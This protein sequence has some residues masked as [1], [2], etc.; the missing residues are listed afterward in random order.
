[1]TE[2]E[3]LACTDPETVL[4]YLRDKV[5]DRKLRLFAVACAR[6]FV[7]LSQAER[8]HQAV[9]LS[10]QF[11]DGLVTN[12]KRGN[13]YR[14]AKAVALGASI[15]FQNARHAAAY[16]A[17]ANPYQAFR[18][19]C[20]NGQMAAGLSS[21]RGYNADLCQQEKGP[22]CLLLRDIFGNPFR[23]PPSIAPSMLT[24]NDAVVVRLAQ[25]IYEDRQLPAGTLDNSRLAVLADALEEAGCADADMLGHLRGPGPHVRGCWVL[26]LCLGKS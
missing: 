14:L 20:R 21:G 9:E 24:W 17:H 16:T 2:A 5:S 11:A 19:A 22:Q 13:A 3:W 4:D 26:D 15:Q 12:R 8:S 1:V 10:E 6:R 18:G 7:H 25:A 23:P